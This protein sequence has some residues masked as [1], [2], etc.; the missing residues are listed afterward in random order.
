M[1]GPLTACAGGQ[2]RR[3]ALGCPHLSPSG[4]IV[5]GPA[6]AR[7]AAHRV[8]V[9]AEPSTASRGAEGSA[10][11][12]SAAGKTVLVLGGCGRVG[13]STAQASRAIGSPCRVCVAIRWPGT[14]RG[15]PKADLGAV[16]L[17]RS[18]RA[19]SRRRTG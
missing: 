15:P 11:G 16:S 8:R 5:W 2:T 3:C 14:A 12:A 9:G 19:F 10:G 4:P 18:C 7:V 1:A 6:R 13:A 17:D